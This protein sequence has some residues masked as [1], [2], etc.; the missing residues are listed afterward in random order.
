[1]EWMEFI[2]GILNAV[3]WPAAVLVV[4]FAFKRQLVLIAPF[5]KKL[6]FKD[7]EVEFSNDIDQLVEKAQTAFPELKS[8]PKTRLISSARHLP[9]TCILEAW[10]QLHQETRN[11]TQAH[12]PEANFSEDTPYKDTEVFLT[13]EEVLDQRKSKLFNELRRLRNKIAHAEGYE[14]GG[15][16]AIQYIELCYRL[17][18]FLKD[19]NKTLSESSAVLEASV[20]N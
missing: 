18:D 7:F 2:V 13:Q 12:F 8:D 4:I 6:K 15:Q 17:I 9:N 1:M 11:L 20:E 3:A 10:D 14:V 16:E 5:T 19:L